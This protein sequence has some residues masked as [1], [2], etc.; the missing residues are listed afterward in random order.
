MSVSGYRVDKLVELAHQR[1]STVAIGTSICIFTSMLFCPVWAG[2]EL[3][4][5]II[6][7]I[8]K[9]ADSLEGMNIY[10]YIYMIKNDLHS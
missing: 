1:L 5:L 4:F 8:Q 6:N 7:N 9:L 3:H 10:I 2:Q